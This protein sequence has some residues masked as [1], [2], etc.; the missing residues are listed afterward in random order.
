M[1]G[2]DYY[3]IILL[4]RPEAFYAQTHRFLIYKGR[5]QSKYPTRPT[6]S[7]PFIALS[8]CVYAID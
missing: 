1:K 3:S 2:M 5:P 7:K 6:A 4:L 8:D